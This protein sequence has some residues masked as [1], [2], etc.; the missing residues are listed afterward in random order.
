MAAVVPLRTDWIADILSQ[1]SLC[2]IQRQRCWKR[3]SGDGRRRQ[4]LCAYDTTERSFNAV[5]AL[6]NAVG[7]RGLMLTGIICMLKANGGGR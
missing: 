6:C 2:N 7:R 5:S 4:T 1:A 3:G